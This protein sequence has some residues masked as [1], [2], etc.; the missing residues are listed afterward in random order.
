[1]ANTFAT[2]WGKVYN[3][4]V[5]AFAKDA[6]AV[7]K[8]SS[9]E[10]GA[11]VLAALEPV[12][13]GTAG[14]IKAMDA[15][16]KNKSG[17]PDPK[18]RK[19]DMA[20]YATAMKVLKAEQMAFA[21][22]ID[23]ALAA[24]I[25]LP[26]NGKKIKV[27]DDA[28]ES[29][30]MLKTLRAELDAV[31]ARATH[32]LKGRAKAAESDKI[33]DKQ[34]KDMGN[35]KSEEDR[36]S[37]EAEARLKKMLLTLDTSFKSS[38]AKGKAAVQKIKAKPDVKTYNEHMNNAGRDISQNLVNIEKMKTNADVK[39]LKQV[40]AMPAPG[41]LAADIAKYGNGALRKL[42]DTASAQDVTK[43]LDDFK[44]LVAKIEA[45]YGKLLK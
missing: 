12:R 30:R 45:Q 43:A 11:A 2:D 36:K 32:E 5:N 19:A 35:A 18:Q 24:E 41:A 33:N 1:M 4:A 34:Q 27:K 16:D 26:S 7:A 8:N 17:A 6:N 40:K 25:K 22:K 15:L 29:Y 21:K 9:R 13:N 42:A 23:A 3:P 39:D 14:L 10:D 31:M 20:A 28:P 44:A 37:V 38:I